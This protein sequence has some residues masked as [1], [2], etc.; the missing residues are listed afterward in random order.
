MPLKTDWTVDMASLKEI[1][2]HV[3]LIK[4]KKY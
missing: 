2:T 3:S 4:N 1:I